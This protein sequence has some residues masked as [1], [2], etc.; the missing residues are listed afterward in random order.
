[1]PTEITA[2]ELG[3]HLSDVLSRVQYR[4]ESFV[5]QRNGRPIATLQPAGRSTSLHEL[6]RELAEL[7]TGDPLFADDLAAAVEEGRRSKV[8][9]GQWPD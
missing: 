8:T 6:L 2:T 5:I 1:V 7:R 9:D 4:G 3:R